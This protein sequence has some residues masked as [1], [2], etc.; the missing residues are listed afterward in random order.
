MCDKEATVHEVTVRQGAKIEKHLC[1]S[2]AAREGIG[3]PTG[4]PPIEELMSKILL[5]SGAA[6]GVTPQR[7]AACPSCQMTFTEFR[8]GGLLG[9]PECYKAFE[10]PLTPL[11]ER[12]HEGGTQHVGKSPR[13]ATGQGADTSRLSALAER[14]ERLRKL[15]DDLKQ[16]VTREEY[17]RAARL[18]DE[19]RQLTPGSGGGSSEAVKESETKGGQDA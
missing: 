3:N 15:Q 16:A 8:E 5:G 9:C 14:A 7:G 11:V 13:R 10:G 2:C 1:E 19:L 4:T 6:G 12:A 17:E 18:R